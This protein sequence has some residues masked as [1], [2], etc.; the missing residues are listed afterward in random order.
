MLSLADDAAKSLHFR[1]PLAGP[2]VGGCHLSCLYLNESEANQ[3]ENEATRL[4]NETERPTATEDGD[5]VHAVAADPC[6]LLQ[7]KEI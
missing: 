4:S 5:T 1:L 6:K 3:V 7:R 2:Y